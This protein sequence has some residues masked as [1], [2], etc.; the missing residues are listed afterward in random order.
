MV[1]GFEGLGEEILEAEEAAEIDHVF[2]EDDGTVGVS[3]AED[4]EG[5]VGGLFGV[6]ARLVEEAEDLDEVG[7]VEGH[8]DGSD[9]E[10]DAAEAHEI[11][12][13]GDEFGENGDAF[14]GFGCPGGAEA[15]GGEVGLGASIDGGEGVDEEFVVDQL[16]EVVVGEVRSG[17]DADAR[18]SGGGFGG[19]VGVG[20]DFHR[21]VEKGAVDYLL[22]GVDEGVG[23]E[24]GFGLLVDGFGDE[25]LDDFE[26]A[27]GGL[28][29]GDA[30]ADEGVRRMPVESE[31]VAEEGTGSGG[32]D[33]ADG[34]EIAFGGL[35]DV[36]SDGVVVVAA[37]D[38]FMEGFFLVVIADFRAG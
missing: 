33:E 21:M 23:V 29:D 10:R 20:D 9:A 14:L 25:G 17:A 15:H 38:D 7:S 22:D 19:E 26:K 31:G 30:L 34:F 8:G 2:G 36:G 3:A 6:V 1:A 18:A 35:G 24:W 27:V 13:A 28:E 16:R 4:A 32:V 37:F 5:G 12:G 11:H